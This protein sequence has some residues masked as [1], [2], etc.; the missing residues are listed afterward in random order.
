MKGVVLKMLYTVLIGTMALRP[1]A[2]FAI[3]VSGID[4][5]PESIFGNE[6]FSVGWAFRTNADLFVSE[7]GYYN[8]TRVIPDV[9]TVGMGFSHE[10][11]LFSATGLLLASATVNPS[12]LLID[13]FR[14]AAILQLALSANTHYVIAGYNFIDTDGYIATSVFTSPAEVS[15]LGGLLLES[16]GLAF[17]TI[18]ASVPGGSIFGP[19]FRYSIP[20]PSTMI[21]LGG[22]MLSLGFIRHVVGKSG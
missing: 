7:L 4:V 12:D 5:G 10:V 17:P 13:D 9:G 11:G 2:A 8:R 16:A 19:N 14:Y 15:Y 18:T 22:A 21:L 6:S 1:P 20:E 3:P